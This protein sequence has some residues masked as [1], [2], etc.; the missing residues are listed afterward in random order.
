MSM[1]PCI[2]CLSK[3]YPSYALSLSLSLSICLPTGWEQDSVP[4]GLNQ[5]TAEPWC[6]TYFSPCGR[7]LFG[8]PLHQASVDSLSSTR[9]P[10][11]VRPGLGLEE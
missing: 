6:T 2:L 11:T 3:L 8:S 5:G 4:G 1:S 7:R 9:M 10:E